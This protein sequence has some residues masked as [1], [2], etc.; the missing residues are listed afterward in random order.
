MLAS[1]ERS[2]EIERQRRS[3]LQ[4][5]DQFRRSGGL[6]AAGC[7]VDDDR[8][9]FRSP[10]SRSEQFAEGELANMTTAAALTA[11]VSQSRMM[12]VTD[13]QRLRLTGAVSSNDHLSDASSGAT[14]D[15]IRKSKQKSA[16]RVR[17]RRHDSLIG[18]AATSSD[19]SSA[20]DVVPDVV[21]EVR[22]AA[23]LDADAPEHQ[24]GDGRPPNGRDCQTADAVAAEGRSALVPCRSSSLRELSGRTLSIRSSADA[25]G[26]SSGGECRVV[27]GRRRRTSRLDRRVYQ[28]YFA[29]ILHS[30]RRSDRFV[31]LQRLYTALEN[32]VEMESQMLSLCQRAPPSVDDDR[33]LQSLPDSGDSTDPS[34]PKHWRQRSLQLRK[35]YAQLDAAQDDKEFFY[36]NGH[37]DAFQWKSW[38]D[39]GLNRKTTSLAKLRDLFEAAVIDNR[40]V[41]TTSMSALQRVERGPSYRKLLGMFRRLEKTRTEA[42]SWMRRQSLCRQSTTGSRN[43]DGTYMKIMETAARNAKTLALHGYHMNEHR[44]RYDAYVQSRRIYRPKSAPDISEQL[45]SEEDRQEIDAASSDDRT[46]TST[47]NDSTRYFNGCDDRPENSASD[48]TDS[49]QIS[50]SLRPVGSDLNYS[51]STRHRNAGDEVDC[52]PKN[53]SRHECHA[54]L[55][56]ETAAVVK[57]SLPEKVNCNEKLSQWH[58]RT[59]D[60]Q[61]VRVDKLDSTA[62]EL[63]SGS[64]SKSRKRDRHRP[65]S[66]NGTTLQPV[67]NIVSAVPLTAA[68][69]HIDAW[70][71]SSRHLSGTLNQALAYFNSL[72][73]EDGSSDKDDR[74][75][76]G[77]S[78]RY[79][80]AQRDNRRETPQQVSSADISGLLTPDCSASTENDELPVAQPAELEKKFSTDVNGGE[81]VNVPDR[82]KVVLPQLYSCYDEICGADFSTSGM[83]C[84]RLPMCR[85]VNIDKH[86]TRDTI[87]PSEPNTRC[88]KYRATGANKT[89]AKGAGARPVTPQNDVTTLPEVHPTY[90]R[91]ARVVRMLSESQPIQSTTVTSS[92]PVFVDCRQAVLRKLPTSTDRSLQYSA[93]HLPTYEHRTVTS[94]SRPVACADILSTGNFIDSDCSSYDDKSKQTTNKIR[95]LNSE[96][97]NAAATA[98]VATNQRSSMPPKDLSYVTITNPTYVTTVDSASF[99]C[100]RCCRSLG[101]CNCV[102]TAETGARRRIEDKPYDLDR[103]EDCRPDGG[104]ESASL[105]STDDM[106]PTSSRSARDP[107]LELGTLQRLTTDPPSRRGLG[108]ITDSRT[109]LGRQDVE[110]RRMMDSLE[111]IDSEW[112]NGRPKR[113]TQPVHLASDVNNNN[114]SENQAGRWN[115]A[116]TGDDGR[117]TPGHPCQ[118]EIRQ[119]SITG[120]SYQ[121]LLVKHRIPPKKSS[122]FVNFSSY[123]ANRQTTQGK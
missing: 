100:R 27:S 23:P 24:S 4:R 48:V 107:R 7:R 25:D 69:R 84:V 104:G 37:L 21:S 81:S 44:N 64:K 28:C 29:G 74:Y 50:L 59:D 67:S 91:S 60:D 87:D 106:T 55:S 114:N 99:I 118:C 120:M 33:G 12:G 47:A 102:L 79:S 35:L 53:Q 93:D 26:H 11:D 70:R 1:T 94:A 54:V 17:V 97:D 103:D 42:E 18:D 122:K 39:A 72:C 38:R 110:M 82:H 43:L 3:Q 85:A 2:L 40:S 34:A 10:R 49:S 105:K 108:P 116:D 45:S 71:R 83:P 61:G 16:K 58:M 113:W 52:P 46:T 8:H 92:S 22:S 111:T 80:V 36:D 30:S 96:V 119:K 6:T 14:F 31:R 115:N 9:G 123:P 77:E 89:E 112:S 56:V 19:A 32:V 75:A 90:V 65:R 51:A 76:V 20:T 117:I 5:V 101:N 15:H 62:V 57:E 98:T 13:V 41:G 68:R 109:V 78:N 121:F 66:G 63:G 86:R 88:C 73:I 95:S